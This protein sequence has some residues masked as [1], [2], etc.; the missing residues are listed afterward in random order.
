VL[1]R[2]DVE[3]SGAFAMVVALKSLLELVPYSL[4]RTLNDEVVNFRVRSLQD[5]LKLS[6]MKKKKKNRDKKRARVTNTF[7]VLSLPPLVS[8]ECVL[9][10]TKLIAPTS[11]IFFISS[12]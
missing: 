3:I 11:V 7:F 9:K 5:R 8:C 1:G 2:F 4:A 6:K 10:T 12:F